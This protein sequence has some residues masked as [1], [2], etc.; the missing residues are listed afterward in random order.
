MITIVLLHRWLNT[1]SSKEYNVLVNRYSH[2]FA[3][4]VLFYYYISRQPITK[5]SCNSKCIGIDFLLTYLLMEFWSSIRPE[6]YNIWIIIKRHFPETNIWSVMAQKLIPSVEQSN[7]LCQ[8]KV[9]LRKE[10]HVEKA[11]PNLMNN[12]SLI[13]FLLPSIIGIVVLPASLPPLI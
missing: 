11:I 4:P 10:P 9:K 2:H 1:R 3:T 5:D 6:T 13:V 8:V 7:C 12:G